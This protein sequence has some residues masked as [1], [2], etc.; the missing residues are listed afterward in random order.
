[1]RGHLQDLEVGIRAMQI[2]FP[3]LKSSEPLS[4][5]D[6]LV[7]PTVTEMFMR[8]AADCIS[9][10]S[11]TSR[12]ARSVNSVFCERRVEKSVLAKIVCR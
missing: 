11:P 5:G 7:L 8:H 2:K 4:H 3:A 12:A 9:T 10:R 1:M 6:P